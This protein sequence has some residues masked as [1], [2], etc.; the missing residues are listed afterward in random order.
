MVDTGLSSFIN[1]KPNKA[2]MTAKLALH[3]KMA[4]GT[5]RA[6]N[7]VRIGYGL[8]GTKNLLRSDMASKPCKCTAIARQIIV[9]N[10]TVP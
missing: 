4:K 8:Q 10:K 9:H 7:A 3:T 2:S 6:V 5:K 1:V